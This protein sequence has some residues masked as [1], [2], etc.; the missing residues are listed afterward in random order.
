M[1][2]RTSP[3]TLGGTVRGLVRRGRPEKSG[4]RSAPAP[5][6][7][8]RPSPRWTPT[9]PTRCR[10]GRPTPRTPAPGRTR[11]GP[12]RTPTETEV[13][14]PMDWALIPTG[15]GRRRQVPAAVRHLDHPQRHLRRH[16]RLQQL[17]ADA[18]A[19]A[20]HAAIQDY[21]AGFRVVGSTAAV[22]ARD[23]T[24]ST[25]TGHPIHWLGGNQVAD[26]YARLLRR[27]LGRRGQLHRRVRER[28]LALQ[29]FANWPFTRAASDDGTAD[30]SMAA[31]R[32]APGHHRGSGIAVVIAPPNDST[33]GNGSA[34]IASHN[35][36]QGTFPT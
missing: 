34:S 2:S 18:A 9:P 15:L 28:P 22:D 5:P 7:S 26:S 10:C 21:S 24:A 29:W 8:A 13:Y 11:A 36:E 32:W 35:G 16:Q 30:S 17:R 31:I 12:R 3:T 19:A 27:D 4:F 23:N 6:W 33:S 14:P 1:A 20:G 25:G